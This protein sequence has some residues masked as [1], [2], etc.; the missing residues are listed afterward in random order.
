MPQGKRKGGGGRG[1]RGGTESN[2]PTMLAQELL[3]L[4]KPKLQEFPLRI[5]ELPSV[6]NTW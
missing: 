5:C 1:E 4:T 2:K 6:S 3:L